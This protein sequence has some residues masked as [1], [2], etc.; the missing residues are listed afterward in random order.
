MQWL[1]KKMDVFLLQISKK[2]KMPQKWKYHKTQQLQ[3]S[4]VC[5]TN[6]SSLYLSNSNSK[7]QES[8]LPC[9]FLV[10]KC[11]F[12]VCINICVQIPP[13]HLVLSDIHSSL[14][15]SCSLGK[16]LITSPV[17]VLTTMLLPTAS[18]TSMDSTFLFRRTNK[19]FAVF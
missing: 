6:Y 8:E 3:L 11:A 14:I 5:F 4:E 16:I 13:T 1:E 19:A 7:N 15:S 9:R 10:F 18:R 12:N 17:L 2:R